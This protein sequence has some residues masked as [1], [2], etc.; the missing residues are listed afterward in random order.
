MNTK[1]PTEPKRLAESLKH[2]PLKAGNVRI[3]ALAAAL[4]AIK[5]KDGEALETRLPKK[6]A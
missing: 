1:A 6:A 4:V 2:D 3:G 5:P